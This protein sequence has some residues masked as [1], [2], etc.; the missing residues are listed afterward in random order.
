MKAQCAARDNERELAP[1][2]GRRE[3]PIRQAGLEYVGIDGMQRVDGSG[4]SARAGTSL[5]VQAVGHG[6]G[7]VKR[8]EDE[9][10]R[11]QSQMED[12]MGRCP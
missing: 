8:E 3:R 2:R 5:G 1:A 6:V 11:I 4:I 7:I 10:A 9:V 12:A